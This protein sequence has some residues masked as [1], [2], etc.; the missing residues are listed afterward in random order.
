M[1]YSF[2]VPM[3]SEGLDGI[4]EAVSMEHRDTRPGPPKGRQYLSK[5]STQVGEA[6]APCC[7]SPLA[8]QLKEPTFKLKVKG[9]LG[10]SVG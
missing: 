8:A 1:W 5:R 6:S 3:S 10:G 2:D 4:T 7:P 9:R